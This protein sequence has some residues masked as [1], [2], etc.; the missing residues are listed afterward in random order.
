MTNQSWIISKFGGSSMADIQA[1]KRCAE[2]VKKRKSNI[3]VVSATF[4]TTNQ[5]VEICSLAELGNWEET[6][7]ILLEICLLNRICP[8]LAY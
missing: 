6:Q 3:V 8:Q 7:K 1:M 4:G 2:V 5:L